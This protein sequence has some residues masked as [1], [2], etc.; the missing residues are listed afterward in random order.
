MPQKSA[1]KAAVLDYVYKE[2]GELADVILSPR[3]I[4]R[5]EAKARRDF[6]EGQLRIIYGK[7]QWQKELDP[8]L[9]S[10]VRG[11]TSIPTRSDSSKTSNAPS[12]KA[13]TE[14]M[15]R[16]L[17]WDECEKMDFRH[18]LWFIEDSL[19]ELS[20]SSLDARLRS[21]EEF[22]ALWIM[23]RG[24]IEPPKSQEFAPSEYFE[25]FL[26]RHERKAAELNAALRNS[27]STQKS[28]KKLR[29]DLRFLEQSIPQLRF[30]ERVRDK[31][32]R[33]FEHGAALPT[34]R[35]T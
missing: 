9:I 28:I 35:A 7:G 12:K 13:P 18:L 22:L 21:K 24:K 25:I 31:I 20:E 34:R 30:A 8:T 14:P 10:W 33:A 15:E 19:K 32:E 6:L 1:S 29:R 16:P 4:Y 3:G 5:E 11:D 27:S 23:L 17:Y 26:D 2:L